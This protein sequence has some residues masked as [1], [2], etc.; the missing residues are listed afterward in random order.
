MTLQNKN[1]D[2]SGKKTLFLSLY[3]RR[4][5]GFIP[6]DSLLTKQWG[7][8]LWFCGGISLSQKI[9]AL[10]RCITMAFLLLF[11]LHIHAR[12][13]THA[14]S[15]KKGKKER[16][17]LPRWHLYLPL[18]SHPAHLGEKR[19]GEKCMAAAG[20]GERKE[21]ACYLSF[22]FFKKEI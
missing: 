3:G 7:G 16:N 6:P 14:H 18:K 21:E 1:Q 15:H 17:I 20:G 22:L 10:L 19:K 8:P 4:I 2:S 13:C 9:Q 11:L 12:W 5:A